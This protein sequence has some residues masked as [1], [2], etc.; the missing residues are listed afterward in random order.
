MHEILK[1]PA[2]S[3]IFLSVL[4]AF[5]PVSAYALNVTLVEPSQNQVFNSTNNVTF[6]CNATD[7]GQILNLSLY[8]N[9]N[10][11]FSV[12]QTQ[13]YGELLF[14]SNTTFLCRFN[15]NLACQG[16]GS[17]VPVANE[18][19]S[20]QEGKFSQG[21]YINESGILRY[22]TYGNFNRNRGTI[23]FWVRPGFNPVTYTGNMFQ[24]ADVDSPDSNQMLL[25]VSGGMM[26]FEIDDVY[27]VPE[28]AYRDISDWQAGSWYHVAAVWDIDGDAGNGSAMDL[29]VNGSNENS[30]YTGDPTITYTGMYMSMYIGSGKRNPTQINATIDDFR[31]SNMPRNASEINQSY[32][33]GLGNYSAVSKSWTFYGVPDGLYSWGCMAYDNDSVQNWSSN[34]TFY[35]DVSSPPVVNGIF[36]F[37]NTADD[38]D[39]GV[40]VNFTANVSDPSG[41][42]TVIFQWKEIGDENWTNIT[43]TYNSSLGLYEN[44]SFQTVIME[45]MYYYRTWSNDTKGSSGYSPT[46]NVTSEWDYTWIRSPAAV[47]TVPG[48]INSLG[49]NVGILTINNTGDR[50]LNFTL[51]DN[52]QLYYNGSDNPNFYVTNHTAITINITADFADQASENDITIIINASHYSNPSSLSPVSLTTNATINS[53]TGGPYLSVTIMEYTIMVSQSQTFNLSAKVK[54]IGNETATETWLNWSLPAGW[55]NVSGNVTYFAGNLSP[56]SFSLSN[57]TINVN[58]SSASPGTFIIYANSSCQQNVTGYDFKIVGV[59]CS[60]SDG[61]CGHGCSYVN[62]NDCGIPTSPGGGDTETIFIGGGV[63]IEQLQYSLG[64][65]SPLLSDINRGGKRVVEVMVTNRGNSTN[66]SGIYLTVSGYPLTQVKASPASISRLEYGQT[67]E[68]S[69]EFSAPNYM[70]YGVYNLT[71]TARATGSNSRINKTTLVEN[72]Q[73]ISLVIHSMQENETKEK[74]Q[75]AERAVQEMIDS[76]FNVQTAMSLLGQARSQLSQWDYDSSLDSSNSILGM[77]DKS[78]KVAELIAQAERKI[79]EAENYGLPTPESVKMKELAKSALQRE[80]YARAE[81]R[82]NNAL[83]AYMMESGNLETVKFF[84]SYWHFIL[85]GTAF[86]AAAGYLA[87]RRILRARLTR[88]MESLSEQE[89]AVRKLMEKSQEQ[90]YRDKTLYRGDYYK[91]MAGYES[92]LARIRKRKSSI[93]NK[94]I[95]LSG[96]K[97]LEN[98]RKRGDGIR[99]EIQD[100]QRKYY[101]VGMM[102]K[103]S[104]NKSMAELK[105]ELEDSI[106]NIEA[107]ERNRLSEDSRKKGQ[108]GFLLVFAVLSFSLVFACAVSGQSQD[109]KA[110]S[111]VIT[112]AEG[113]MKEMTQMGFA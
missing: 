12:N 67:G 100:L 94:I 58:P 90:M 56:A 88:K 9:L 20:L 17:G 10:G 40:T 110:A 63:V 31:I 30:Y 99:K 25:Y 89:K 5:L 71:L 73:I 81:E 4:F 92:D 103:S 75:A 96:A 79:A 102:E 45:S 41:V 60:N 15:G 112:M 28:I 59:S 106:R 1:T 98:F 11:S 43:M 111:E 61:V 85:L 78:L 36:L 66:L 21:V 76:G 47:G 8:H 84:Y 42:D 108:A 54:N 49:G 33:N 68:F 6:T 55:S 65:Q 93:T 44:T 18:S 64:I 74:L 7:E 97:S 13:N 46:Q 77:R 105:L 52:W 3:L 62:D 48:L 32:Q 70:K 23:E 34:R 14:D 19:L 80:D 26:Y 104:Y 39:P 35:V 101:D 2:C 95:A 57:V 29:F 27:G 86:F 50:T 69:L 51:Y 38:I 107:I 53:Y 109:E 72:I 113:W 82:A 91:I 16:G 22:A 37:P 83:V 24:A 87:N